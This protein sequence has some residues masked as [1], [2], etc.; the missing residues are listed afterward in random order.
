MA[1]GDAQQT[2]WLRSQ[3]WFAS[4]KRT[5]WVAFANE[6]GRTVTKRHLVAPA[7]VYTTGDGGSVTLLH[8]G[9]QMSLRL[10]GDVVLV[11]TSAAGT[12]LT[13]HASVKLTR[14]RHGNLV[15]MLNGDPLTSPRAAVEHALTAMS[16]AIA[17]T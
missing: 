16:S 4:A 10:V 7:I 9:G 12:A 2:E 13:Q 8:P 6:L 11:E 15:A 14:D 17:E 5:W 1:E 3:R